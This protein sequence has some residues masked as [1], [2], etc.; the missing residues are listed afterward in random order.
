MDREQY[1]TWWGNVDI[2]DFWTVPHPEVTTRYFKKD[3]LVFP[4]SES[5]NV[6]RVLDIS[7]NGISGLRTTTPGAGVKLVKG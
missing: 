1:Q 2:N 7:T 4:A 6:N 3:V 5:A